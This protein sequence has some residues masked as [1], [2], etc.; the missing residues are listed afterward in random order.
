MT[1]QYGSLRE[2]IA[3]EKGVRNERNAKFAEAY[4]KAKAAGLAAGEGIAPTPM[5]VAQHANP[6][7][8]RSA[9][10][11]AW[12]VGEG[13]CGFAWVKIRPGTSAFAKWLVKNHYARPAWNGGVEIWIGEHNQSIDRKAAHAAALAETLR[14]ELGIEAYADSRM[15]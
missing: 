5:V 1:T 8:D 11:K 3:A 14:A 10:T 7:N 12:F 15:D 4:R 9:V 13:A 6:M 2:K